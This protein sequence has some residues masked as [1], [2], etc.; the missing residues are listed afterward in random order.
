MVAR[1]P[2]LPTSS[3]SLTVGN[4]FGNPIVTNLSGETHVH[5]VTLLASGEVQRPGQKESSSDEEQ[6]RYR[7]TMK[8]VAEIDLE[9]VMEFC[10]ADQHT[11]KAEEACLTGVMATNVLLRDFPSKTYTQVGATGNKFYTLEGSRPLP[12]GAMVCKGFLQ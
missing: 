5:T 2:S 7:V 6:R 11:P 1:T 10:R 9:S 12:Q 4:C 3:L 8:R